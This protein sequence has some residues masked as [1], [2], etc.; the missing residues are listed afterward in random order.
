[1]WGSDNSIEPVRGVAA[2]AVR[3]DGGTATRGFVE[4][5]IREATPDDLASAALTG[6]AWTTGA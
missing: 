4:P 2:V 5:P 3:A 6:G 1:M